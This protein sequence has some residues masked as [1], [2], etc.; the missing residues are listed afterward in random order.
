[1]PREGEACHPAIVALGKLG[2]REPNYHSSVEVLFFY[3]AEGTT[4]PVARSRRDQR[5]ANN[6][7]FTQLAQRVLKQLSQLTPK[8]RLYSIDAR[9]RPIGV[10]GS[11]ALSLADFEQHFASG[12]APLWQWQALCQA[13][14]VFGESQLQNDTQRLIQRL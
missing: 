14:P 4:R 10:G 2:G 12:A 11:L 7:F 5:T 1:G 13:R 9:L 3:E 6:H 8:G